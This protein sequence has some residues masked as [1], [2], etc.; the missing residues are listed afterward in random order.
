MGVPTLPQLHEMIE[1]G[2]AKLEEMNGGYDELTTAIE[3]EQKRNDRF[4]TLSH[5][6]LFQLSTLCH[7]YERTYFILLR[8]K[9]RQEYT[10]DIRLT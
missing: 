9:L 2:K 3:D 6:R 1:D 8:T 7:Y 10:S 4:V 5:R